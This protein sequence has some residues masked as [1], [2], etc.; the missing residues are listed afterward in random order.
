MDEIL[1][2]P[3]HALCIRFFEG[4]GYSG[5]FTRHMDEIIR[6]LQEPGQYIALVDEEDEICRKCPN[7]LENGCRQKEKVKGYDGQ[8]IDMTGVSYVEKIDFRRLQEMVEKKIM[9][10]GK[11]HEICRD[12]VWAEICH[13]EFF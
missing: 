11:F 8:V 6:R 13:K 10:T 12:C 9:E 3:H 5:E 2:R 4:K 7:Y 1:L